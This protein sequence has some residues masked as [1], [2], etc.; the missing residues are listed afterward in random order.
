MLSEGLEITKEATRY[1]VNKGIKRLKKIY[2]K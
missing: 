2:D 1:F